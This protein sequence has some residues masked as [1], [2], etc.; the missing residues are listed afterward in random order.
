MVLR[1]ADGPFTVVVP[2]AGADQPSWMKVGVITAIGFLVGVAWPRLAGVRIGPSV[3]EAPSSS[4]STAS[5]GS[6]EPPALAAVS[7]AG[8]PAPA[9]APARSSLAAAGA[10]SKANVNVGRGTVSGCKSASGDSLKAS[11]CGNLPG[12]D[13]VLVPRLRKLADCPEVAGADGKLHFLVHLDFARGGVAVELGRARGV[14]AAD[15]LLACAKGD[16]SG[17]SLGGIS[18][19]NQS[20]SVS[21]PVSFGADSAPSS[22]ATSASAPVARAAG[23]AAESTAQVE[24][25]VAIVRDTPK[26]GKIVA[27]LQRGTTLRIGAVADGWYPVKYGD[28]FANEG[29]VYRAAIGR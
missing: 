27:R 13:A 21:Y 16:V 23:D 1:K 18:H 5:A 26:T 2:P 29:Y 15:A 17:V 19:E 28:G 6:A 12:L 25:E 24:W 9:P 14:S 10:P 22:T 4:V 20:Y 8:G 7:A 3:P 11:E